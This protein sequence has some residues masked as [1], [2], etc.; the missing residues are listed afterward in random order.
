MSNTATIK[1]DSSVLWGTRGQKQTS[2]SGILTRVRDQRT[3][4]MVEIP[5]EDGFTVSV[6]LLSAATSW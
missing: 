5:D 3:G 1:G 6:V 4:E 2:Y